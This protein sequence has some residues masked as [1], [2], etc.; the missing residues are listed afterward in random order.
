MGQFLHYP[1]QQL[2]YPIA[3]VAVLNSENTSDK[4][5][6]AHNISLKEVF[7]WVYIRIRG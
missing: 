3:D 5:S 4:R 1:A 2:H 7:L 6:I